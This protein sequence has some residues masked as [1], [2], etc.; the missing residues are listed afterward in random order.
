MGQSENYV[1]LVFLSD[2][3]L[4]L[5]PRVCKGQNVKFSKVKYVMCTE[6]RYVKSKQTH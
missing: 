6:I 1:N 3:E 2:V 5:A 4:D